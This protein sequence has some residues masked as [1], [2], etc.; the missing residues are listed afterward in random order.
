MFTDARIAP[1]HTSS[2]YTLTSSGLRDYLQDKLYNTAR[3][4][5]DFKKRLKDALAM[6]RT[7]QVT[8]LEESGRPAMYLP[9]SVALMGRPAPYLVE[10]A[11]LNITTNP[12]G[13]ALA[14]NMVAG[15][16]CG[17]WR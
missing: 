1:V 11:D 9:L 6:V 15:G 2:S 7:E 16:K 13:S 10:D 4:G 12:D 14:H 5:A 8:V 17:W 3:T